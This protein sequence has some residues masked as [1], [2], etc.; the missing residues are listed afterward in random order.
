MTDVKALRGRMG[1]SQTELARFLCVADATISRWEGGDR[2]PTG[3]TGDDLG[4][5]DRVSSSA[6]PALLKAIKD[7]AQRGET[8]KTLT[9]R[10]I[11]QLG[12]RRNRGDQ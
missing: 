1:W 2:V 4:V 5:L 6:T 9:Q 11:E 3:R 7:A 12:T 8:I 10:A